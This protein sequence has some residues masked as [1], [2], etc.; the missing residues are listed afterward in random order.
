MQLNRPMDPMH[1]E[2]FEDLVGAYA[3]DAC[4]EDE[5]VALDAYVETNPAAYAEAERLRAAA[6]WLGA[7]GSLVPPPGLRATLLARAAHAAAVE[8][9]SGAE[10]YGEL[11]ERLAAELAALPAGQVEQVTHNGLSVRHLVAHLATIDRVFLEQLLGTGPTRASI[12]AATIEDVTR[13]ALA[14]VGDTAFEDVVAQWR[15]TRDE[16]HDAATVATAAGEP[17]RAVMGYSVDDALLIRAFETWTHLD[18]V[19]RTRDR[20]GYVPGGGALRAMADLSI[21]ILPFALAVTGRARSGASLRLVMTGPG[22]HAWDV[23]LA[24]GETP[25]GEPDAVMTVDIVDWCRRFA[26]R[27]AP[28]AVPVEVDGDRAIALDVLAAA[29][30]FAGL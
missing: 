29:P 10:A 24:P 25:A 9:A 1:P 20:A 5:V 23:P 14:H 13:D 11:T 28:E 22:G 26:D 18:D 16:L 2:R 7:S 12:D 27:I 3:L 19:R 15:A 8:P 6:A 30:V 4:A 17:D 21:R